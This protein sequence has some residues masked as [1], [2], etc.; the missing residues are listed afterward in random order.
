[1]ATKAVTLRPATVHDKRVVYDWLAHSDLTSEML[2][3]PNYPDAPIP[4]WEEFNEDYVD[5][6]FDGSQPHK[7]QCFIIIHHGQEIG[8]INHN[9]IAISSHSTELD[10]WLAAR[11]FAGQGLGTEAVKM[12]CAFLD[13]TYNCKLFYMAPSRRNVHAIKAYA[14]AGFKETD[15]LPYSF[16]PDY[17]DT[18]IMSKTSQE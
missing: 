10:I 15:H 1:M 8:Q 14:K 3:P 2:G 4:T 12:L 13:K 6:Y 9:Q 16:I 17:H 18:V 11:K 5:H 7:G